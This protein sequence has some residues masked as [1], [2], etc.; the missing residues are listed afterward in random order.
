MNIKICLA[1]T[2]L[3]LALA[4][5]DSYLDINQDPNAPS[6]ADVT[7]SDLMPGAE[8]ALANTYGN[9]LR[10]MGGYLSE[11]YAHCNGTANYLGFS[12]FTVTASQ[13]SLAYQ[14]LYTDALANLKTIRE[15]AS[16]E[17]EWG[18][19]L[20][21]ATLRAFIFQTLTDCY[22]ETPYT[23]ALDDADRT[24][25][26]DDGLTVYQGLLS[27]LDEALAKAKASD[28]VCTNFLY[29][30]QDAAPWVRFA[31]ALKLKLLMRMASASADALGKAKALIDEDDLPAADVQ[32][33][34]LFTNAAGQMNPFYA[35][36]FSTAWGSTSVNVAANLAI[37]GTMQPLDASGKEEYTDPRLAAFFDKNSS[38]KYTG[39]VSGTQYSG[40]ARLTSWCRPAM[41]YD[42]PVALL[43]V[44]ETEFFKAEYYARTGNATEAAAH[45]DRAVRASFAS[46]GVSG[47][48]EHLARWPF[49]ASDYRQSIGVQK[50]VALAGVNPFEA[51]CEARRLKYPAFDTS[52]SGE[53]FFTEGDDDSFTNTGYREGTFYTPIKVNALLGANK[54]LQR[55]P[56]PVV[57]T[58]TNAGAPTFGTSDCAKPVF[59][60]E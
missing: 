54:L 19:C 13:S 23:E 52:V 58:A 9:S 48:D 47:A 32:F 18:T 29:A 49:D 15:K 60:A 34:G 31:K 3:A 12:Q 14:Q 5:C 4:S 55:L 20:A 41:K 42:T 25:R 35:E 44:A 30:G 50:W 27:E 39:S 21:A 51:W 26:Y 37:I 2:A 28:K 53:T 11:V 56:Y 38:G 45:Y 1:A 8:L 40:T 57:S 7:A 36:E 43:T 22:G 10:I 17:G 16:A 46:A 6:T 24:P 59:W 33:A